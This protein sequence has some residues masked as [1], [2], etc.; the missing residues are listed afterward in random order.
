MNFQGPTPWHDRYI[1]GRPIIPIVL[2]GMPLNALLDTGSQISSIPYI[3]YKRYWADADIDKGPSDVELDIWASNDLTSRYWQVPVAERDKEKTAFTTPMGLSEFNRMPFGLC[4]ASGTFQRLM[5][6]CLGHKNF[7]TVLLYL[8]DVIVYSKTYEQHLKDLAEVFE[9]LSRYGMK[10]K[11]SKCHL[12]KPKVQY[13]GHIVSSEGV[14]PDPEKITTIRDWPRPTSAKEVRQF[15]GLVGYYRRF[16][17]GFTKLAAPLQDALVGQTKKPSNRNPPFQWNDEREDSFEQLKKALTGEEV[18]AY[19]DYHQPFILYTDASNVGLGAVL[20]QKQE[21]REK[22]IA[23]A[24]RKLRPTERNP[25]NYS[26]FKLELLAVVWAVTERFKHYLAAAEFVYT[27]NNPLTHLDTA[28]LGA[29][30]QRWIARLSNYNFKIKY[31]AGRKN[32]NADALSRM[33]HLRDVE[34]ETGELEEIELQ[35]FHHPKA[36]HHQSSTYQ[37]QQE[38]NFNPLAHHRWADT[39]DSN[40]AVKLVKE[41]LTEQSAY[42]DED[43]PEE[44]HQLWKERGKMFLY[45][46][47]LC[48]RYTNPKTHE[49]V[50]QII[51]PKQDVKMVLEAY[52]NGAG[53]FGW[54]KLEVL[55][56]ERFYWVGMRKSIEQWCRNCGPCNLRRNDQKNQRAPLQPIITKQPLEL[57]AIDHVK[58]IPSRSG[59]VYALTIVDHKSCFL[60]VVPVK[61]LT[62][63]TAAKTFQMYFCRPHG[64]P[65]Q[66]L[67]DQVPQSF[68]W[69]IANIQD[70][71]HRRWENLLLINSRT[72]GAAMPEVDTDSLDEKQVQLLSE[73]CILIDEN[74]KKIGA[75]TKKNCHLNQ[76]IHKGLLHRAFS[77]FLFNTENKLLLQQRSEAKITFPGCYTNTCCS[78]PLNTPTEIEEEN[79]I[80]VRRAAQRRLKAELGIP[81][82][83]V[84]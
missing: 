63:K 72:Y 12:L 28:K 77:V 66:V 57:V 44:T 30:E 47:K 60:V 6:C 23:F 62:A 27:D 13:L 53:H 9:A 2:D 46:G 29:L 59:Y 11:P 26:S 74:D 83:Q 17:K 39:Q 40:P 33:P 15:L 41:L 25:E 34:E 42:P 58:L 22:V 54:K 49:L 3:L 32:G 73:M 35:A 56:R 80:G 52:H 68:I 16:I 82:E 69:T 24:S 7:E 65:E 43:A 45:Q 8:D 48:R 64:Y 37:K 67:T 51:V 61:D 38:V 19:P 10:V 84:R 31:R 21:G 4:N 79:S 36:K 70:R 5:E 81:M 76:N 50:W 14:A 71:D 55:L 20:S 1:G 75:D 18:L 78:H